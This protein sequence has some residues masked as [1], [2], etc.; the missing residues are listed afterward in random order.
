VKADNNKEGDESFFVELYDDGN[1]S[2]LISVFGIGTIL[3]DD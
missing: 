1:N 2:L 3:N